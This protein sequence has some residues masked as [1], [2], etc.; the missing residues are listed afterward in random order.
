MI[1]KYRR[2]NIH[3]IKGGKDLIGYGLATK[4]DTRWRLLTKLRDKGYEATDRWLADCVKDVGTKK[5]S[6]DIRKEF[7]ET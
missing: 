6:F 7:L 5:S 1:K 4:S 2:L 3:A